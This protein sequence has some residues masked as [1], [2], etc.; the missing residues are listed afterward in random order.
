MYSLQATDASLRGMQEVLQRKALLAFQR[1]HSLSPTDHQAAFYL[2]LQLAISRQIP[3]ALG[4]I[5]QALQLQDDDANSLHLLALLLS[6]QKHYHD[7]LNI[8]DMALSEYPGNFILLFSKVKLESLCP[9]PDKAL[10]TCKHMLQ[11]WKSCYNLTNPSDSGYF[12]NPETGSV[13]ATSVAASRVE[14]ALSEVALSLQSSAPK[15]CLLQPWVTLAQFW[16]HAAEVYIGIRKPAEATA[17][18]QE[19]TNLFPMSH[20][21]LYMHGQIAELRGAR[22]TH[23]KSMQRLALI[24]H[25]LGRYSLAEKMLRDVVQVNSTAHEVWNGL[26]KVLQAQ[27]NDAA[28]T[29]CFLTALEL[30]T[31]SPAVPFTIIPCVL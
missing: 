5:C 6:A 13:H 3:E 20:N 23:M 7:A 31:S 9:G 16:L 12:S 19:A 29:E 10:L 14:Q 21:V 17:C 25:Q 26:G 2:A 8:I 28:A 18:T 30:E 15:Q 11:I 27:G 22:P 4:Y 1:A 24:L